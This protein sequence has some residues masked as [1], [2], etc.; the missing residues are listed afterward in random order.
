MGVEFMGLELIGTPG[1]FKSC[2]I[3]KAHQKGVP[4]ERTKQR[5][6]IDEHFFIDIISSP[7]EQGMGGS[8]H[9]RLV[10]DDASDIFFFFF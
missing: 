10:L 9:C 3:C 2:T 1:N 8:Q 7:Q 6:V 5:K 4:K